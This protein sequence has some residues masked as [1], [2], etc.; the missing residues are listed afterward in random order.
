MIL[1]HAL[2][3]VKQGTEQDFEAAPE[4]EHYRAPVVTK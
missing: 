3:T 4:V 1:E 2:I